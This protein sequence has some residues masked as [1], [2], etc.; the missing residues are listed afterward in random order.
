[1]TD[2]QPF[3][4]AEKLACETCCGPIFG[5]SDLELDLSH[6]AYWLV[7]KS[8]LWSWQYRWVERLIF[9]LLPWAGNIAYACSCRDK[10]HAARERQ[11]EG[12]RLL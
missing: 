4:A 1:M 6:I 8:P 7:V 3:T 9:A 10:N 11:V 12:E 2:P 5:R